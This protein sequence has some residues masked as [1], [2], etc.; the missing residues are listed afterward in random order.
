[1]AAMLMQQG[2]ADPQPSNGAGKITTD[3]N[4]P[5]RLMRVGFV[6]ARNTR[7]DRGWQ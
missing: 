1:M 5:A 4:D 3:L 7:A 6:E 2:I